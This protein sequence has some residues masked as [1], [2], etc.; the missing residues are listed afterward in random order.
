VIREAQLGAAFTSKLA[1]GYSGLS[2]VGFCQFLPTR[3][4]MSASILS[5][6]LIDNLICA[7]RIDCSEN[8][9]DFGL[10]SIVA[11][12]RLRRA[13]MQQKRKTSVICDVQPKTEGVPSVG[14]PSAGTQLTNERLLLLLIVMALS[15]E[16][17]QR[18]VPCR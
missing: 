12:F 16:T 10:H 3:V 5:V 13:H 11:F 7:L 18:S 9:I 14:G 1:R 6:N 4:R 17:A 8:G 15:R 2:S